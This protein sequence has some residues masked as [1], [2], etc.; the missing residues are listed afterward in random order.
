MRLTYRCRRI[1]TGNGDDVSSL[2]RTNW[3]V[4]DWNTSR[5]IIPDDLPHPVKFIYSNYTT[6]RAE[7]SRKID[8]HE[9]IGAFV[10]KPEGYP[11]AKSFD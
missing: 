8:E 1:S 5:G 3:N 7:W 4:G 6:L 9:N 2:D 10:F 11:P